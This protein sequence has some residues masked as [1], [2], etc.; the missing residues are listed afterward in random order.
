MF[1]KNWISKTV[2][3]GSSSFHGRDCDDLVH[4]FVVTAIFGISLAYGKVRGTKYEEER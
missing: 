1:I 2:V 4:V 3:I